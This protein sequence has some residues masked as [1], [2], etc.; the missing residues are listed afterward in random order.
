M[1]SP[2]KSILN[3]V[4]QVERMISEFE[5]SE[6]VIKVWDLLRFYDVVL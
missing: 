2:Q 4:D 1:A 3:K 6:Y 5:E